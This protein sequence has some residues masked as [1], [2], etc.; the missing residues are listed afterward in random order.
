MLRHV[1]PVQH[2][3]KSP[4]SIAGPRFYVIEPLNGE[5]GYRVQVRRIGD[6]KVVWYCDVSF[7]TATAFGEYQGNAIETII[8]QAKSDLDNEFIK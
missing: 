6:Q 7:E 1:E 8:E 3:V 2:E 4:E 5:A